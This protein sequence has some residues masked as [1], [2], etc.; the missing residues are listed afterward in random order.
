L[1]QWERKGVPY[2]SQNCGRYQDEQ[3][4]LLSCPV[5]DS[6]LPGPHVAR[7]QGHAAGGEAHNQADE[8]KAKGHPH[9]GCTK[10]C[11]AQPA[12]PVALRKIWKAEEKR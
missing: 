9:A 4:G 10:C 1:Q 3:F 11:T 5:G 6:L 8:Y 7:H 12:Q 2:G